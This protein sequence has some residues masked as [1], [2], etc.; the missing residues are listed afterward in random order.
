MTFM[1]TIMW[2]MTA[3]LCV[4]LFQMF[5]GP[6]V[7][8]RLLGMNLLSS[9]IIAM[10]I[11]GAYLLDTAYLLDLAII[12]ALFGFIGEIFIALFVADRAKQENKEKRGE[13]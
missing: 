4:F 5:K 13:H 1:T 3:L 9:K 11:I 6:S 10:V 7:W 8:D 12:Y 2:V